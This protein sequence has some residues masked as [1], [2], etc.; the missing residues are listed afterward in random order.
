ML[1]GVG[2]TP[3]SWFPDTQRMG[4]SSSSIV[5]RRRSV[6]CCSVSVLVLNEVAARDSERRTE[7]VNSFDCLRVVSSFLAHVGDFGREDPQA[8]AP[9]AI[10]FLRISSV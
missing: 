5:V 3:T 7:P 8:L 1:S 6:S 2:G 9:P 4:M 10:E